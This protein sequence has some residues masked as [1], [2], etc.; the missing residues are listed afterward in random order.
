MEVLGAS[1]SCS[2]APNGIEQGRAEINLNPCPG[3]VAGKVL[4]EVEGGEEQGCV[5]WSGSWE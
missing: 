1:G 3:W 4:G 2:N 5:P